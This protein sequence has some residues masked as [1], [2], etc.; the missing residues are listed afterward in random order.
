MLVFT[1]LK[2]YKENSQIDEILIRNSHNE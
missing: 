2:G 1:M